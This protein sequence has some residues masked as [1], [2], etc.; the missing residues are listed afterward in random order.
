[1]G[2]QTVHEVGIGLG[3]GEKFSRHRV[4]RHQADALTR[5]LLLAHAHPDIGV[6]DIGILHRLERIGGEL[7]T[8]REALLGEQRIEIGARL[9]ALG[10]RERD[11][12][13]E[14]IGAEHPRVGHVARRI[15]EERDLAAL[16]RRQ[17]ISARRRPALGHRKG[18]RV[19][20]AGMRK[21]REGVDH[22]DRA[23]RRQPL[24]I[25][26]VVRAHDQP[27][28]ETRQHLRSVLDRLAPSELDVVAVQ[29][30]RIAA[31]LV[32]AHLE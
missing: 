10:A 4:R 5:L 21:I 28:H 2:G 6:N 22:R 29:K 11:L 23:R 32:H 13:A 20:L 8:A 16:E 17:Q 3:R 31:Q 7:V 19:N 9:E 14:Q 12:H 25:A 15:A 26:V 30:Q 27:M 1:M 24:H 18:I